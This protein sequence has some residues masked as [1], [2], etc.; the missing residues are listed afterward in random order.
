MQ[1]GQ[2][3]PTGLTSNLLKLF[4][5]RSPLE[6]KPPPKKRKCPSFTGL[7]LLSRAVLNGFQFDTDL[8]KYNM[9]F[10]IIIMKG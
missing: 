7:T 9:I 1:I 3:H 10:L 8:Y 6:F 2:S 4:E 5:P